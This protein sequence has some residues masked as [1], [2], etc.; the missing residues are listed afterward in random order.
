MLQA[1]KEEKSGCFDCHSYHICWVSTYIARRGIRWFPCC[2]MGSHMKNAYKEEEQQ[3]RQMAKGPPLLRLGTPESNLRSCSHPPPGTWASPG[4]PLL[5]PAC[6]FGTRKRLGE[7][8]VKHCRAHCASP[9]VLSP[10][11]QGTTKSAI[12]GTSQSTCHIMQKT[13]FTNCTR[14]VVAAI[15]AQD[16]WG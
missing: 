12:W 3:N 14:S 13:F 1:A 8:L 5:F 10:R 16:Y 6:T 4:E 2:A 11:Y 15:R 9:V 7:M